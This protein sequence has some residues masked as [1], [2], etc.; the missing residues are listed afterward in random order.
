[1]KNTVL[2][3]LISFVILVILFAFC[4]VAL[5]QSDIEL[6]RNM[7]DSEKVVFFTSDLDTG[8]GINLFVSLFFLGFIFGAYEFISHFLSKAIK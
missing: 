2:P 6:I 7:S 4:M 8:V 5:N 3:K 1:M